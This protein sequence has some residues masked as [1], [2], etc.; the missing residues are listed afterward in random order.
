MRD[1]RGRPPAAFVLGVAV[2]TAVVYAILWSS[3]GGNGCGPSGLSSSAPIFDL[4]PFVLPLLAGAAVSVC[5]C[6]LH[7]Q[8][9][10]I[11]RATIAVVLIAALGE[12]L[13]FLFE[14][15]AHHC[16]D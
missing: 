16:G 6:A 9:Q 5:G 2:M 3:L 11:V 8:T 14:F 10:V 13:V 15:S 4:A 7:W 1:E 12:L